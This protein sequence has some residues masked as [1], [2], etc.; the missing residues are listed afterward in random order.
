MKFSRESDKDQWVSESQIVRFAVTK[1]FRFV[2]KQRVH[3]G[4]ART[5]L[6]VDL[7]ASLH[8]NADPGFLQDKGHET[9]RTRDL[10]A[11]GAIK[12]VCLLDRHRDT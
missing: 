10:A 5:G 7:L 8:V 6:D 2:Q 1:K 11:D 9:I 4:E 3:G 12:G